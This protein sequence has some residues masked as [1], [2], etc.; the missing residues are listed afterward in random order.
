MPISKS[1]FTL[2]IVN[3]HQYIIPKVVT[4]SSI[5]TIGVMIFFLNKLISLFNFS[6]SI[7]RTRSYF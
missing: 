4:S 7:S 2:T 1:A 6:M 5:K 3:S